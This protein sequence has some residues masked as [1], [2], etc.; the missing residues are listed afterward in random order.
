MACDI[1][2]IL[3]K[4]SLRRVF[5]SLKYKWNYNIVKKCFSSHLPLSFF[6]Y[7]NLFGLANA[8]W[9]FQYPVSTYDF[10][11]VIGSLLLG[12]EYQ[13]GII[14]ILPCYNNTLGGLDIISHS[15]SVISPALSSWS[16]WVFS[17]AF[18]LSFPVSL[19]L[20]PPTS[21]YVLL[22]PKTTCET[23]WHNRCA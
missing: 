2:V 9:S 20:N 8:L 10:D 17:L 1:C 18:F 16:L 5:S 22:Y 7:Y 6:S 23:E 13:I 21:F 14:A 12:E 15:S 11:R 3:G 4:R 19:P